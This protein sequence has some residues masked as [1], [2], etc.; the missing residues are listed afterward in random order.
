MG[1]LAQKR[2]KMSYI[3]LWFGWIIWFVLSLLETFPILVMFPLYAYLETP[4]ISLTMMIC[5][6]VLYYNPPSSI[7]QNIM[8]QIDIA[9][10]N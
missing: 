4:V 3:V 7:C 8:E 5:M 2:P 9:N 1:A 10:R 6:I